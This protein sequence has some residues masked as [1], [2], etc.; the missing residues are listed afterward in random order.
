[1]KNNKAEIK[2]CPKCSYINSHRADCP[3][4]IEPDRAEWEKDIL[5]IAFFQGKLTANEVRE[6]FI[7]AIKQLLLSERQ[8]GIKEER[9]RWISQPAN[10]HDK[11]I[12]Q[13]ERQKCYEEMEEFMDRAKLEC[14]VI[15]CYCGEP[16]RDSDLADLIYEKHTELKD[17]ISK[18]R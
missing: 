4:Y 16:Y 1:M 6:T 17:K 18:L 11:K 8:K 9:D 10:E 15:V 5:R 7:P 13:D 2:Q 3:D 14:D 12:R